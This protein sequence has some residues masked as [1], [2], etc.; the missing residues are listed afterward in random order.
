MLVYLF[1]RLSICPSIYLSVYLF[2]RLSLF[3]IIKALT[4]AYLSISLLFIGV[5]NWRCLSFLGN[6]GV[7]AICSSLKT[8]LAIF[9]AR[10]FGFWHQIVLSSNKKFKN[11]LHYTHPKTIYVLKM[12]KNEII[13]FKKGFG[14]FIRCTLHKINS[15]HRTTSRSRKLGN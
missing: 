9:C 3:K 14:F 1:V 6:D 11:Q 2:V 4:S 8:C 13:I 12:Q 7:F 10:L 5:S 15:L